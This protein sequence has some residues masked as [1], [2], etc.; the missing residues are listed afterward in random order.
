MAAEAAT[1]ILWALSGR[2]FG[3]CETTVRPCRQSW[4]G[5]F[6]DYYAGV[7]SYGGNSWVSPYLYGG[8]WFNVACGNHYGDGCSCTFADEVIL[9]GPVA[10]IIEISLDGVVLPT[11][12][13]RLD[14]RRKLVRTDGGM[15]P[16]CQDYG[17]TTGVGVWEVTF[18]VGEKVP[19]LGELAC[20]ELACEFVKAC[21]APAECALPRRIAE[22]TRQGVHIKFISALKNID[23]AMLLMLG[24]TTC[25][26]FIETYNPSGL[27]SRSQVWSPDIPKP[28][29]PGA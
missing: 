25:A 23:R 3:V 26:F 7:A 12:S 14:D 29:Y 10:D 24:L 21:V 19:A 22:L 8:Q 1:E 20:G 6:P 2:Q 11:G 17:K 27:S 16:L 4:N 13:Y 9:P 28:R 5:D 18:T 15:W